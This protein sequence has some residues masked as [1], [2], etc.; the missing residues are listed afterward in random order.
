MFGSVRVSWY[1]S[2]HKSAISRGYKWEIGI[3]DIDALYDIQRGRCAMTGWNIGWS[4]TG[5]NHTASIDRIN[6]D[7]NYTLDNIQ[8]VHKSVNMCRGTMNVEEFIEMCKAV[9][10]KVKW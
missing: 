7:G 2:F 10:D 8:I 5:Q 1:N 9:A 3:E 4:S 6:N